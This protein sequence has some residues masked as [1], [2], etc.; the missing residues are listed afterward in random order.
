M[1]S[2]MKRIR[3]DLKISLNNL[4]KT[5]QNELKLLPRQRTSLRERFVKRRPRMNN[6]KLKLAY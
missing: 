1:L 4:K 5:P 2:A 6:L 3:S